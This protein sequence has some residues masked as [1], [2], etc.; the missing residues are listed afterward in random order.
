MPDHAMPGVA[1]APL[2]PT[3]GLTR[4]PYW[5]FQREDV[6]ASEQRRLFQGP[7]WHFLCM[8]TEVAEAGDFRTSF[9]GDTPVIVS[10]DTDG[11]IHVWE[12]RCAHRGALICLQQHGRAK[13]FSCVYHAWTYD[14]RGNLVGVAFRD[15]IGG[16]GGMAADFKLEDH[17]PRRLRVALLHGLIFASFSDEVP[18][19]EEYLGEEIMGRI[20]RVLAGRQPVVGGRVTQPRPNKW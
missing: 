13:D 14:L 15:G 2:W 3:D 1:V 9:V 6:Y 10:R 18:P 12:N 4:I 16:Q 7:Y 8:A 5:V 17:A 11:E 19:I 20:G